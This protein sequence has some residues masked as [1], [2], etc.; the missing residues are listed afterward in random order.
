MIA[1]LPNVLAA[2]PELGGSVTVRVGNS[3]YQTQ[4]TGT[5]ATFPVARNWPV[6]K[7]VFFSTADATSYASVVVL[8]Q[9][10]ADNLFTKGADPIG[11][12]VVLNNV[13]FQVI[14]LMAVR[15]ASPP[16][17]TPLTRRAPI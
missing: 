10:V 5:T 7:G 15:G 4:A 9:T 17:R 12:Y 11:Q 6:S 3:D 1:A 16:D 2:V 13:L 8:G 14:G